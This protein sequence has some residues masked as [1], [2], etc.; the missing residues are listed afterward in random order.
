MQG[1]QTR[2]DEPLVDPLVD[3]LV[4]PLTLPLVSV[5]ELH[6]TEVHDKKCS[7]YSMVGLART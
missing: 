1:T 4:H 2:H 5:G 6:D 7:K 3:P